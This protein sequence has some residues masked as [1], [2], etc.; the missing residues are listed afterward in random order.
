[1]V[2]SSTTDARLG[3]GLATSSTVSLRVYPVGVSLRQNVLSCVLVAIMYGPALGASPLAD[4]QRQT[5]DDVSAVVAPLTGREEAIHLGERLPVAV[6]LV[7]QEPREL[8]HRGVTECAGEAVIADHPAHVQVF[9][10]DQIKP[11]HDVGRDLLHVVETRVGDLRLDAS[12]TQALLFSAVTSFLATREDALGLCEFA[13]FS[14]EQTRVGDVLAVGQGG[15]SIDSEIDADGLASLRQRTDRLIE[16]QRHEV[17]PVT[18]LGYRRSGGGTHEVSR[19]VDIESPEFGDGQVA[20]HGVPLERTQGVLGSLRAMLFLEGWVAGALV[21]EVAE[22]SLE[23]PKCLLRWDTGNLF[24]PRCLRLLLQL[25]KFGGGGVV[26]DVL[27]GVVRVGACSECPV[28]DEP[29][30][31]EGAR[32]HSLL[33]RCG[34]EPKLVSHLH[35]SEYTRVMSRGQQQRKGSAIP[36]SAKPDGLLALI[37]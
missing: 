25:R 19:P 14:L 27:P 3:E 21:E 4:G 2:R 9:Y 26:V 22:R 29:A 10:A 1:M 15:E 36:P 33:R 23:M 18:A 6:T 12:N 35:N 32:Q 13:K 37:L 24:D 34:V 17:P 11:A 8:P 31:P 5:I 7:L 16:N 20:V 30:S 28:V